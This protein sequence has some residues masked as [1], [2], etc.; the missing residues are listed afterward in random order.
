VP[1]GSVGHLNITNTVHQDNPYCTSL[2]CLRIEKHHPVAPGSVGHLNI[3]NTVHQVNPYCIS[4]CCPRIQNAERGKYITII[5]SQVVVHD[6]RK[7]QNFVEGKTSLICGQRQV[8]L[9]GAIRYED[10]ARWN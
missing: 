9:S 2:Y 8:V 6:G 3:T 10:C 7:A 5:S 1:P 4:L